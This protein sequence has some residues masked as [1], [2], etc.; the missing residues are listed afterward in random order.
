MTHEPR[1]IPAAEVQTGGT[2]IGPRGTS[3]GARSGRRRSSKWCSRRAGR[4]AAATRSARSRAAACTWTRCGNKTRCCRSLQ[5]SIGSA[6]ANAGWRAS[7]CS[8]EARAVG[9]SPPREPI[10]PSM[11]PLHG[12]RYCRLWAVRVPPTRWPPPSLSGS[13]TPR[14]PRW[15]ASSPGPECWRTTSGRRGRRWRRRTRSHCR[16]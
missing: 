1:L 8:P 11:C 15:R 16:H 14:G 5:A 10:G 3:S 6:S 12:C 13:P 9:G 2:P 4:R 7:P